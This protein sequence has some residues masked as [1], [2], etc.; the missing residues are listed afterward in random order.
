MKFPKDF[1]KTPH[2]I[3]G[4]GSGSGLYGDG[5]NTFEFWDFREDMPKGCL[6]T[7]KIND[8]LKRKRI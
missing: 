2:Q 4:G 5:V 8:L 6:T 7:E 3:V 1:I